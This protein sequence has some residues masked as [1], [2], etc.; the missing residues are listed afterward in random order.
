M[1]TLA[2]Q[3]ALARIYVDAD[4]RAQVTA[5]HGAAVGGMGL[6]EA[7]ARSLCDFVCAN[8]TLLAYF[9]RMLLRK[10]ARALAGEFPL[11]AGLLGD[12]TWPLV[13]E[14][15][16][17]DGEIRSATEPQALARAL[18]RLEAWRGRAE[19]TALVAL[20]TARAT[21]LGLPQPEESPT[22]FGVDARPQLR[23]HAV[24]HHMPFHPQELAD[25]AS[26][27]GAGVLPR[28]AITVL[29]YRPLNSGLLPETRIL[30]P[31]L[32]EMLAACDGSRSVDDL[33]VQ[34][35]G[36]NPVLSDAALATLREY[37]RIG[38]VE[39]LFMGV[40]HDP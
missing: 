16:A 30:G 8:A 39:P 32:A 17:Y 12:K 7:E 11:T 1:A 22:E 21:I 3:T 14:G 18:L 36:A 2:F 35:A 34:V 15:L 40:P 10:R 13:C 26:S 24:L 19:F 4:F 25:W 33:L 23:R 31:L 27:G 20:E 9:A 29:I 38:V 28:K 37:V 5:M 6:S